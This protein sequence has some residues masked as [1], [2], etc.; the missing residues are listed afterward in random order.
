[1]NEEKLLEEL[2]AKIKTLIKTESFSDTADLCE[3]GLNSIMIM[4]IS[5]FLR[6]RGCRATFGDLITEPTFAA[7][8]KKISGNVV[9]AAEAAPARPREEK[10]DDGPFALTDVQYAYWA[11]RQ[12]D[13]ELGGV[14]CH[15]Y[16]EFD[17]SI[18]SPEKL[19]A[20]WREIQLA[21]PML[22]ARFTGDGRQYIP[23]DAPLREMKVWDLR[24]LPEEGCSAKLE[25][26]RSRLSHEKLKVEEGEN[27]RLEC[28]LL[29]EGKSRLILDVDLLVADV[30]SI[31]FLITQ[32][33]A[34]YRGGSIRRFPDDAFKRHCLRL[35]E[36]KQQY[37]LDHQYWLEKLSSFPS[38]APALPLAIRPAEVSKVRF[39]RKSRRF[40]A[41]MWETIKDRARGYSMTPAMFLLTVYACVLSR[42][43]TQE[44]FL[45]N[46]PVFNRDEED[47]EISGLIADFTNLML[48]DVDNAGRKSFLAYFNE[49]KEAFTRD[50]S[51]SG[52]S[53][54]QVLRELSRRT[55][56]SQNVAPV[57]FA[58]NIDFPFETED[59]RETLGKLSYMISQTPQVWLDF[60]SFSDVGDLILCWDYVE[61]LFD[62][63]VIEDMYS[64][65][66]SLVEDLAGREDWDVEPDVF[67]AR[68]RAQR[69]GLLR[70]IA[71][72]T[73]PDRSLVEGF[74]RNAEET[75]SAV[76]LL[77]AATGREVTY[78]ELKQLSLS[79]AAALAKRGVGPGSFVGVTLP[80]GYRQVIALLGVLLSGAAYVP[81]AITQ[82][83]D[84]RAKIYEQIAVEHTVTDLASVEKAG[85]AADGIDLIDLD[86]A[87]QEKPLPAA[88]PVRGTDSA[89]VI[90]TSG[91]TGVP[92]GVEIRHGS[93]MNTILD[94]NGKYGVTA[95]DKVLAVSAIDF[96][97]SVY[98]MF[99]LLTA[100]GTVVTLSE[101]N[102]KNPDVWLE[103]IER[104]HVTLWNTVPILFNMLVT[105]AE[106]KGKAP[107][108]RLVFLSGDWIPLDLPGRFYAFADPSALVVAM[109]GATEASIWSNYLE[110]PRTV[111]A[112]WVSI[113][114]GNPLRGQVYRVTDAYGREC[115][116]LVEGELN[117]GGVGVARGYRGDEKLT[118]SKFYRDENGISWYRT[119]DNG[120]F[121]NDQIIE[122]LGRRDSQVKI[123]GHRIELGEIENAVRRFPG[124]KNAVVDAVGRTV[125]DKKIFAFVEPD[126]LP[127]D[128]SASRESS[129]LT[130]SLSARNE[131]FT[132]GLN[133]LTADFLRGVTA[134]VE[135][136]AVPDLR[137]REVLSLWRELAASCTAAAPKAGEEFRYFE[138]VLGT[139]AGDIPSLLSGQTDPVAYF[140]DDSKNMRPDVLSKHIPGYGEDMELLAGEVCRL[141]AGR[142]GVRVL[143]LSSRDPA[144]AQRILEGADVAEYRV[145]ENTPFFA[146]GYDAV[147]TA[148]PAF[149]YDD[150]GRPE[151]FALR[152]D[153]VL[154]VYSLHR[155]ADRKAV[156][157]LAAKALRS[158]GTFFLYEPSEDLLISHVIPALI[159]GRPV[160]PRSGA[161]DGLEGLLS[162][163][164]LSVTYAT[165]RDRRPLA[166]S[167][168]LSAYKPGK[169]LDL[170]ALMEYLKGEVPAYM[171]PFAC[172]PLTSV[173]QTKN[174]K[175]DHKRLAAIAGETGTSREIAEGAAPASGTQRLLSS[176]FTKALGRKA[177]LEDNYFT[178]GGDSLTA[179]RII[180]ELGKAGIAISIRNIFEN[181]TVAGLAAF[182][183]TLPRREEG[184]DTRLVIEPL[185]DD[186]EPFPLTQVQAAYWI[187]RKGAFQMGNVSTQVYFE[188]DCRGLSA[189]RLQQAWNA[190]I[191]RHGMLRSVVLPDGRQRISPKALPYPVMTEDLRAFD[192]ESREE[193]LRL[194]REKLSN[195]VLDPE[196]WPL[197]D[198]KLSLIDEEITRL[199]VCIDNLILD[200][201]SMFLILDEL[202]RG[203]R[204]PS[205]APAAPDISFRDYVLAL[206][207]ARKSDRYARD[208]QY[209]TDR[210]ESFSGA[211]ALPLA[212]GE[213]T[214][215]SRFRR[216]S[217]KL[218]LDRRNRL[219][220][221]AAQMQV[222]PAV[223]IM[224]AFADALRHF[225]A[226]RDFALNLTQFDRPFDAPAADRLVGDFTNL[227][228]AE[229]RYEDN[230]T[231]AERARALQKRLTEDLEHSLYS[232]VEFQRD[233]RRRDGNAQA[234]VMPVIFTSGVGMGKW[235]DDRWLGKLVCN[236][237][238][239]PQVWLDHQAVE[240]EDGLEL[241]WDTVD[242]VFE[243]GLPDRMFAYYGQVIMDCLDDPSLLEKPGT[244][245]PG[246][247]TWE[248]ALPKAATQPRSALAE[249]PAA[250]DETA[251][252]L[253]RIW[254]DILSAPAVYDKTFFEQGGDSLGMVRMI[255]LIRQQMGI[256]VTIAQVAQHDTIP[257]LSALLN[258]SCAEGTI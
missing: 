98:D 245:A 41:Q 79:V 217:M 154:A 150:S 189:A 193:Y 122:F 113:P 15:A 184:A 12:D 162:G 240:W 249:A 173:P 81:I 38:E 165:A 140:Y 10:P 32:L 156:L 204:D 181:P 16:F 100:G 164:G 130:Q 7:W 237:S 103:V 230:S 77:D 64:A 54:V 70:Q 208:R 247:N 220:D 183:D 47:T 37:D 202:T 225:T 246:E 224:T 221:L 133:R 46:I 216:R 85:L 102:Y 36:N 89:Y 111:P 72:E 13:Q 151:T 194:K 161:Y 57:V 227:T 141:L 101:D 187:G 88:V 29:P 45:I 244:G 142:E 144:L 91:S 241:N 213:G 66:T 51:H 39:V 68:Q 71:G 232:G 2:S 90:M 254:S 134:G 250:A 69:E 149:V 35:A 131:G 176:V 28:F 215:S 97:L 251:K 129:R 53:G 56:S 110:V 33:S 174:G 84:R 171:L 209:W 157:T 233:L 124:V 80:R 205:Y 168:V 62:K 228:M 169:D 145:V 22:R 120:R 218:S 186:F 59:T 76:A 48:L 139:L 115:P 172:I 42:W 239:T 78:G 14:G 214:V 49:I 34:C 52:Y 6:R 207:K 257:A 135:D 163:A 55:G 236:V 146:A 177:G 43:N 8:K 20:A 190:I 65:M 223:F 96:D 92:K 58:C 67:P 188:F 116:N 83:R 210:L 258:D 253:A 143:D 63:D 121:W 248:D 109:G 138:E 137:L 117:I 11:G 74:L 1:M 128:P 200:G 201:F 167:F 166:S 99:G 107:G 212:S 136:A 26:A 21:Q 180:S 87:M 198:L 170:N 152:Y 185:G 112:H 75:P 24:Q 95:R 153:V 82:P 256:E 148:Y 123:K 196:S 27:L 199:H 19:A 126:I 4:K 3:L 211:P 182:I 179:T 119:G 229:I 118:A 40:P 61:E 50:I 206:E 104:E 147:K 191:A 86:A 243:E 234:P 219:F 114:Y 18:A 159:E 160:L 73:I 127:A 105:M 155:A 222:T 9:S 226:N 252:R 235:G 231:F 31:H 108:L 195:Q 5:A 158:G 192:P 30:A 132:S 255:N 17:G 23:T 60:Q 178:L 93:A 197:F 238:Q 106:G 203:Y 44:K 25:E 94:L 125:S 242:A 175:V